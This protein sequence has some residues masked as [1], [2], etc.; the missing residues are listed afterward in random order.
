MLLSIT[1]PVVDELGDGVMLPLL[2]IEVRSIVFSVVFFEASQ[3]SL[4]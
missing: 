1:R 4:V 2:F 3:L